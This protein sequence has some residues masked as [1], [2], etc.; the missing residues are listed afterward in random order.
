MELSPRIAPEARAKTIGNGHKKAQKT[1]KG[2]TEAK[3]EFCLWSFFL[4]GFVPFCGYSA[5]S[6][7]PRIAFIP[8]VSCSSTTGSQN[9]TLT[10]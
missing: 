1:Q 3:S 2:K 6:P 5:F 4:C 10:S 9:A 7:H 8:R